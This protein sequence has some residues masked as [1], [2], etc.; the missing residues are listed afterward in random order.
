MIRFEQRDKLAE[1]SGERNTAKEPR[2][3]PL[4]SLAPVPCKGADRHSYASRCHI[5][6]GG[7]KT[8]ESSL[9]A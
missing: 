7:A 1:L 5:L 2:L 9:A 8:D 4:R 3:I 6:S